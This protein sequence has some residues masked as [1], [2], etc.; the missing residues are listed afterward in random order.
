LADA[1]AAGKMLLQTRIHSH[2][3]DRDA[4]F[5]HPGA[6]IEG[7][8]LRETLGGEALGAVRRAPLS[9]PGR[10]PEGAGGSRANQEARGPEEGEWK[11]KVAGPTD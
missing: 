11:L 2:G 1:E 3:R 8:D 10:W 9:S 6:R 7:I 5:R 4:A